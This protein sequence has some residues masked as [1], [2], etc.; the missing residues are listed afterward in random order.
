MLRPS[1]TKIIIAR[2]ETRHLG[3]KGQFPQYL[4]DD[5]QTAAP[6]SD[7]SIINSVPHFH[8]ARGLPFHTR[9]RDMSNVEASDSDEA[10]NLL[11]SRPLNPDHNY[12]PSP[13]LILAFVGMQGNPPSRA[14]RQVSRRLHETPQQS[15]GESE[16]TGD[17]QNPHP[18]PRGVPSLMDTR[19]LTE[20]EKQQDV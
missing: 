1:A 8:V 14:I 6:Q 18:Y 16:D 5:R 13:E 2:D 17:S 7:E 12:T 15:P 20:P 10:L 4:H 9:A 3:S 19:Y 11:T